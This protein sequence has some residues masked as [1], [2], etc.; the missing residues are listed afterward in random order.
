MWIYM[1]IYRREKNYLKIEERTKKNVESNYFN[2]GSKEYGG[3]SPAGLR[4]TSF[5]VQHTSVQTLCLTFLVKSLIDSVSP[6]AHLYAKSS[7][8]LTHFSKQLS[9]LTKA[10]QLLRSEQKKKKK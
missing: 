4:S 7:S 10:K 5:E 8:K 1:E 2:Y 6:F 3:S 9:E